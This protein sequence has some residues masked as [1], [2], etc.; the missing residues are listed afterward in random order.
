MW[1]NVSSFYY[2]H[3]QG[4]HYTDKMKF[5]NV[6]GL[7]ITISGFAEWWTMDFGQVAQMQLVGSNNAFEVFL[8]FLI[9]SSQ[10]LNAKYNRPLNKNGQVKLNSK[11]DLVLPVHHWRNDLAWWLLQK[12]ETSLSRFFRLNNFIC[13]WAEGGRGVGWGIIYDEAV[14]QFIIW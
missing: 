12:A 3:H 8:S 6:P 5:I 7:E 10:H 4:P 1:P 14:G 13:G 9:T 2:Q 11:V